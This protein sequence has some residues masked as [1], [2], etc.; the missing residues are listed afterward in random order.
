ML[1]ILKD[2]FFWDTQYF[3]SYCSVIVHWQKQRGKKGKHI[4]RRGFMTEG[5]ANSYK[6]LTHTDLNS[7]LL[8]LTYSV[9]PIPSY[10]SFLWLWVFLSLPGCY[11][12]RVDSGI[13]PD[14]LL[15][16]FFKISS[17]IQRKHYH[18]LTIIWLHRMKSFLSWSTENHLYYMIS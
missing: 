15:Y 14:R 1:K 10:V 12:P 16:F 5:S 6:E 17:E 18:E 13:Q 7:A 8:L 9:I 4:D 3:D 11:S 2:N